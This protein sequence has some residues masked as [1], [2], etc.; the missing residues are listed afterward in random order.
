MPVKKTN[1]IVALEAIADAAHELWWDI[2][3]PSRWLQDESFKSKQVHMENLKRALLD[4]G[5][6]L[7]AKFVRTGPHPDYR[8]TQAPERTTSEPVPS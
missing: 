4:F 2:A 7:Q 6:P 8:T 5:Y 3:Y 1:Q